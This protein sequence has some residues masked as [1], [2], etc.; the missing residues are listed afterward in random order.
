LPRKGL[1]RQ[2][3]GDEKVHDG[4]DRVVIHNAVNK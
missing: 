2:E 3:N 4:R 1:Y